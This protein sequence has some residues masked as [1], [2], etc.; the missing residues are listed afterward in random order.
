[1]IFFIR[2][3]FCGPRKEIMK[4]V[5]KFLGW[6][7]AA[8]AIT[9]FAV[10]VFTESILVF[11]AFVLGAVCLGLLGG[12]LDA[13]MEMESHCVEKTWMMAVAAIIALTM[14]NGCDARAAVTADTPEQIREEIY[15]GE[16][17]LLA[18]LVHAEAE[19]EDQAGKC[20]VADAVLNRVDAPEFPS[21]ISGVIY[22]QNAFSPVQDGR[23]QKAFFEVTD[24]DYAAVKEEIAG[25]QNRSVLYFTAGRYS[26]Y[27]TP[28]FRHGGHYFSGR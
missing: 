13:A 18:A 20:L 1:M 19:G 25:R 15:Q 12:M 21:T 27:G 26:A 9:A 17:S 6:S 3:A 24:A 2:A 8:M 4:I 7:A 16:L 22:Q 10:P 11:L 5:T 14:A 23:L 28:L